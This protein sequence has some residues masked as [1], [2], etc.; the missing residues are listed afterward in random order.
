MKIHLRPLKNVEKLCVI[1]ISSLKTDWYSAINI[2]NQ[3]PGD[4]VESPNTQG[5]GYYLD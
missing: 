5:I 1:Y 2:L 3:P 4:P